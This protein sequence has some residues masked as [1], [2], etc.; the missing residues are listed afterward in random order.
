[1]NRLTTLLR[2]SAPAMLAPVLAGCIGS[3]LTGDTVAALYAWDNRDTPVT[4]RE[5]SEWYG[6]SEYPFF[7]VAKDHA[8]LAEREQAPWLIESCNAQ[9]CYR[10]VLF[11]EHFEVNLNNGNL[12]GSAQLS[13]L[14][15]LMMNQV[16]DLPA[17]EVQA[18][19]NAQ[20]ARV[21]ADGS[22][23]YGEFVALDTASVIEH[24]DALL[25][26]GL[27]DEAVALL[28]AKP[29]ATIDD[30]L[31]QPAE[32][33]GELVADTTFDFDSSWELA[34]DVDVSA[35][36]D[37][38]LHYLLVCGEFDGD[39]NNYVIDYAAC[40]LRAPL[41]SGQWQGDLKLTGGVEELLA[42]VMNTSDPA[43][44]EYTV[45]RKDSDGATLRIR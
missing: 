11:A 20:A 42:V 41:L 27:H 19:L 22:A 8:D 16:E 30:L 40:Q 5:G 6:R 12:K 17:N 3:P 28:Q 34:I 38:A 7:S 9:D 36:V 31:E 2:R 29:G 44:P 25:Y 23:D 18:A 24:R 33:T 32:T 21:L 45:W 26:S 13:A 1:M 10:I 4:T 37:A 35:R 43:N 39:N 15:T 14:S